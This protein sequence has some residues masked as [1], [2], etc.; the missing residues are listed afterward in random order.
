M[1]AGLAEAGVAARAAGLDRR[2]RRR[3]RL[4][5]S[6]SCAAGRA[7]VPLVARRRA[8]RRPAT[9]PSPPTT[10]ASS[11]PSPVWPRRPARPAGSTR[12]ARRRHAC[13]T[14]SG[15]STAAGCSRRP[16]TAKRSSPARRTCSTTPRRRPTRPPRSRCTASPRSP[17][18]PATPTTPTASCSCS[19]PSSTRRRR[20]SRTRSPP[21]DLH[22]TGI[23]EVAVVGDRPDLVAVVHEAGGPTSCWPGASRYDSPLWDGRRDGLA[24]VCRHYACQAPPGHPGRPPRPARRLDPSTDADRVRPRQVSAMLVSV[25]TRMVRRVEATRQPPRWMISSGA[26]AR[27]AGRAARAAGTGARR[28][29]RRR[30]SARRRP[31]ERERAEQLHPAGMPSAWRS[32]RSP[33]NTPKNSAPSPSVLGRQEHRHHRHRGVD[34]SSTAPA[35]RRCRRRG[36]SPACRARSSARCTPAGRRA[37]GDHRRIE[38]ALPAERAAPH[39]RQRDVPE[40]RRLGALEHDEVP[41]LRLAGA[42]RARA[43][44]DELVEQLGQ[45]PACRT[46]AS[47]AGGGRRRRTRPCAVRR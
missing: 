4:P 29:S 41:A 47:S 16:T 25:D 5:P 45:R 34:R 35:T 30:R 23:T 31:A 18:R 27:H 22:A 2:R 11:T 33:R 24:Y 19:A 3:R 44:V 39:R 21:L 1:I 42:R 10:P 43:E 28:R 46:T 8:T 40:P 12:P 17:A 36:R 13:S 15:T 9:P 14:T 7:L 38:Q 20:R 26:P 32:S 6:A 37:G